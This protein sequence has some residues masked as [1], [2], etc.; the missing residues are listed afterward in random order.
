MRNILLCLLVLGCFSSC[1]TYQY[2]TLETE[3]ATRNEAKELVWENDTV[4]LFFNFN[5]KWGNLNL[6]VFNKSEQPLSINWQ[7]SAIVYSDSS[8]ILFDITTR[9][10]GDIEKNLRDNRIPD[11]YV[12]RLGSINA[13]IATTNTFDFLPPHTYVNQKNLQLFK[14][15]PSIKSLSPDLPIE[16][17]KTEESLVNYRKAVY[18]LSS[19]PFK[20]KLFLTYEAA[21]G[22]SFF[23]QHLFYVT[24]IRQVDN[25][26]IYHTFINL[27]GDKF[28]WAVP[29]E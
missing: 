18:D 2:V 24:E 14:I 16:K 20:F 22:Q 13:T 11:P 23:T 29:T 9:I 8:Y 6:T 17:M 15:Q 4:K 12:K 1:R 28:Y 26:G 27:D 5:G 3:K 10:N 25:A 7:K 21:N 19:T